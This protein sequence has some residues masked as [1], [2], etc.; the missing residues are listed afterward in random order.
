[1]PRSEGADAAV[2]PAGGEETTASSH[3]WEEGGTPTPSPSWCHLLHQSEEHERQAINGSNQHAAGPET[4]NEDRTGPFFFGADADDHR[5]RRLEEK[6]GEDPGN[7][8]SQMKT[9]RK[10][11]EEKQAAEFPANRRLRDG[12]DSW[13]RECHR[14]ATR[15][16][17]RENPD[18]VEA[19]N[20]VRR[21]VPRWIYKDGHIVENPSPRPKSRVF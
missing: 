11:G 4:A 2:G 6:V 16:W 1:V 20:I 3:P 14:E 5:A 15:R 17:R 12:L 19:A 7:F 8:G 18:K 13:C 21:V 10:C 9:C